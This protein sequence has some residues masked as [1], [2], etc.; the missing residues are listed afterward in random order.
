MTEPTDNLN[1]N[2]SESPN[3]APP[4][5]EPQ[6]NLPGTSPDQ[7]G[8]EEYGPGGDDERIS[9]PPS[10][11]KTPPATTDS[12]GE[13]P[14]EQA[15][16]SK[17]INSSSFTKLTSFTKVPKPPVKIEYSTPASG[18]SAGTNPSAPY[19]SHSYICLR[20]AMIKP[21]F[22]DLLTHPFRKDL[23][24]DG[25]AQ[26]LPY[27]FECFR[28]LIPTQCQLISSPLKHLPHQ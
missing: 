13:T 10:D 17:T 21:S 23:H 22:Q 20:I 7:T 2:K 14:G 16:L 27:I 5:E 15:I 25:I 4:F 24:E 6:E 11:V 3:D 1:E 18:K 26:Y 19:K 9:E 12:C 8:G 28:E